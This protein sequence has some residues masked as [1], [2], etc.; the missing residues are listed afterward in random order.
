MTLAFLTATWVDD[1]A[2]QSFLR[3]RAGLV[4]ST[5]G[6]L[7]V[8]GAVADLR[9]ALGQGALAL[10][11]ALVCAPAAG[12]RPELSGLVALAALT[13]DLASAN[14]RHV[15]TVPQSAFEG[16]PRLL[17][18]IEGGRETGP[19]ARTVPGLSPPAVGADRLGTPRLAPPRRGPGPL[20]TRHAQPQVRNPAG[21]PLHLEHRD[22]RG[23]RLQV[24]LSRVRPPVGCP[25][26]SPVRPGAAPEGRLSP[27][28]C[29]RPLG[30]AVF[31]PP[32]PRRVG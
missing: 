1:T 29:V 10:G 12:R 6:P 21:S 17:K 14:A 16:T 26:G 19:V 23:V 11:F 30:Y 8:A 32:R 4:P 13:L 24:P 27:A 22:G 20:G 25:D 28:A 7:D 3:G 15:V 18:A 31:H 9:A 2:L 5:Y